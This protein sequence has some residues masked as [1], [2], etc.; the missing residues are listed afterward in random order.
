MGRRLSIGREERL[1]Y[2]HDRD[3]VAFACG[4]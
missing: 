3:I 4:P 2:L 1:T